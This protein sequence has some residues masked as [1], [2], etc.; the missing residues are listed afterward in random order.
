MGSEMEL[1]RPLVREILVADSTTI[2]SVGGGQAISV[3]HHDLI[4]QARTFTAVAATDICTLAAAAADKHPRTGLKVRLTTTG[5]LP[6]GLALATDYFCIETGTINQV[7]LASSLQNAR[8]GVAIDIT[9][10]GSGTHTCTPT[11]GTKTFLISYSVDGD[12]W[13]SAIFINSLTAITHTAVTLSATEATAIYDFSLA[14]HIRFVK[15]YVAM[16]AG[17][18]RISLSVCYH[19]VS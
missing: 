9:D 15:L 19:G 18:A 1:K 5:T 12:N 6:A 17:Q 11:T 2:V 4:D 3:T 13:S 14:D 16:P 7:K 8:D 10:T